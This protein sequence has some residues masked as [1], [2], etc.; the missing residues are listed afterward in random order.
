MA[1]AREP[2]AGVVDREPHPASPQHVES[3]GEHVVV[4]DLRVLGELEDDPRR[5]GAIEHLREAGRQNR[6]GRHVERQVAA[7]REVPERG[8]TGLEGGELELDAEADGECLPE[9][10][11]G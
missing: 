5:L 1:Q 3:A 6:A 2:R 8:Q 11:V 4:G 9:D 10:H 7:G